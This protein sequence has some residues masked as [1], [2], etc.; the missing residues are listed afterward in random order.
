MSSGRIVTNA[1]VDLRQALEVV[2]SRAEGGAAGGAGRSG[3]RDGVLGAARDDSVANAIVSGGGEIG[4]ARLTLEVVSDRR[5]GFV[6]RTAG[7]VGDAL[8]T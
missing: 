2:G 1:V 7:D 6:D 5:Q 4:R 3:A 8:S